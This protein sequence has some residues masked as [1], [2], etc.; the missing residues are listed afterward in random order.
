V[1][2]AGGALD[3]GTSAAIDGMRGGGRPLPA[4]VRDRMEIAFGTSLSSVRIHDDHR[5]AALNDA[6]SARAFTTGKDIFFAR[7]QFAPGSAAGEHVLAHELAHTLQGDGG[8]VHRWW[9]FKKDD[10]ATAAGKVAMK[11]HNAR[12]AARKKAEADAAKAA[13]AAAKDTEKLEDKGLAAEQTLGV[14]VRGAMTEMVG[15]ETK[16]SM[17]AGQSEMEASGVATTAQG[18][19]TLVN[20][21]K[22]FARGLQVEAR[23]VKRLVDEGSEPDDAAEAAY[24]STWIDQVWLPSPLPA[25]RAVRPPRETAS[26]RLSSKIREQ[27]NTEGAAE[28]QAKSNEAAIGK[29]K[30]VDPDMD[31]IYDK[32]EAGIRTGIAAGLTPGEAEKQA[33]KLSWG[34]AEPGLKAKRPQP[35]VEKQAREA[36]RDRLKPG[37]AKPAAMELIDEVDRGLSMA[38]AAIPI[39]GAV[40]G[41]TQAALHGLGS[42][43]DSALAKAAGT[44][45][46][47]THSSSTGIPIV[48]GVV[49]ASE[50]AKFDTEHGIRDPSLKAGPVSVETQAGNGI[51]A[52]AGIIN[53]ILAG[54]KAMLKAVKAIGDA[55]EV[56]NTETVLTATK[57]SADSASALSSLS[58]DAAKLAAIIDGSVA[59]AVAKVLPGFAIV[60]SV[61]SMVSGL[62][63]TRDVGGQAD[64]ANNGL[65]KLRTDPANTGKV[66][67]LVRPLQLMISH[68]DKKYEQAV[69]SLIQ[70]VSDTV[71]NITSLATAGGFGIPAA[72]QAGTKALDVLH[73]LGHV[74]DDNIRALD[75]QSSR[76]DAIGALE[77]S[78]EA[79]MR[80][81][82]GF[83]MD[84][85]I[86]QAKGKQDPVALTFLKTYDISPEE[87][88]KLPMKTLRERAL[89]KMGVGADPLTTFQTIKSLGGLALGGI[90]EGAKGVAGSA[91]ATVDQYQGAKQLGA[92]RT[93]LDGQ[94]RDWKWRL[95]MAFKTKES[96]GRS[97]AQTNIKM[98]RPAFPDAAGPKTVAPKIF[99]KVGDK[100]LFQT[101]T[102]AQAT[103]FA[104][105]IKDLP[106]EVLLKAVNDPTTDPEWRGIIQDMVDGRIK[107]KAATKPPAPP[108]K[109]PPPLPPRPP[110]AP[111]SVGA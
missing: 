81:D 92:D 15:G 60:T 22:L 103:A 28:Q 76:K 89:F 11:D 12:A 64:K 50:T 18:S 25:L 69:W 107:A 37:A 83:A 102:K 24:K 67:V 49:K 99:C 66:D 96:Y 108:K 19:K 40:G 84:A 31:T 1:G 86:M 46:P 16:A 4:P 17:D 95:Q 93:S 27:R 98:G 106:L 5:A 110:K 80:N 47:V 71:L 48:G 97:V 9:P 90:A 34:R 101:A 29:G 2:I 105:S 6:V 88:T 59:G 42:A 87:A 20:V 3:Q 78:A 79:Q 73:S 55:N 26:E 35:A 94:N 45:D 53:D 36:A 21:Q 7:G 65:F 23:T 41:V 63:R 91:S 10:Q 70:A 61:T 38:G 85:I 33:E 68:L 62:L 58:A 54:A 52:A 30:L 100:V 75:A 43:Q 57:A 32:W 104:E 82:P 51:S 74:I 8:E 13:V 77:G 39:V 109:S 44:S 72:I 111:A 56:T 14:A